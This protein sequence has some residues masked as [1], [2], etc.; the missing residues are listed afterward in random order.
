MN[1]GESVTPEGKKLAAELGRFVVLAATH[2]EREVAMKR[3]IHEALNRR[4]RQ[5][6][7][8]TRQERAH[9]ALGD[10]LDLRRAALAVG[11]VDEGWGDFGRKIGKGTLRAVAHGLGIK[12]KGPVKN[13]MAAVK[14]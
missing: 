14:K 2:P 5:V 1:K 13:V 7:K 4:V 6:I 8:E 11:D 3:K 12:T 9:Q 10:H